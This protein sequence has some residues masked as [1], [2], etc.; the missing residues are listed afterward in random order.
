MAACRRSSGVPDRLLAG[1][2]LAALAGELALASTGGAV[3]TAVPVVV[4]LLWRRRHP[5]F[6][7][8]AVLAGVTLQSALTDLD[9]L[10][11]FDIA[12][13]V[14]AAYSMAAYALRDAAIAGLAVAGLGAAA[15][16]ASSIPTASCPRCSAAS[17][18]RGPWAGWSE[19]TGSSRSR[20]ARRSR[21][22]SGPAPARRAPR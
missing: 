8:V 11:V 18:A 4:P 14:C 20:I 19:G 22:P 13:I 6:V 1:A 10:P 9:S 3:L 16:A 12:A 21:A 2:L 5:L 7:V 17:P 15:H